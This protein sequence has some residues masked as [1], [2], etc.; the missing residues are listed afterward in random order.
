MNMQDKKRCAA[1]VLA[2]GKGK[3]MGTAVAKQYMELAGKPLIYYAL[4]AFQDSQIMDTIVLVAG[5][6][7]GFFLEDEI[8]GEKELSQKK[9]VGEGGGGGYDSVWQGLKALR[10]DPETAYVFI[11]DGAR[12]FVDE[13]ILTRGYKTVEQFAACVAGMPSKDTVKLVDEDAFAVN[14]PERK[15]V[16]TVQTP[17]I[18]EKN[19]ITEAYSRLMQE[20][21][22]QVTDD[23][24]AVELMM[25]TPV[26]L[27]EGSYENIKITTP[28]DLKVAE[29]FLR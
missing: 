11:H 12:P 27:F 22:T 5:G 21:H 15:Y 2:A 14:T 6:G 29:A 3:R 10:E 13:A 8:V 23:A 9:V 1:I 25:K 18:F 4:K 24:M 16:W 19:L 20:E 7:G 26:K 17:Q 28:E